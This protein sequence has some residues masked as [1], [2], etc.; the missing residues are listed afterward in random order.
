[1]PQGKTYQA[2]SF[3]SR[4]RSKHWKK[5]PG[6]LNPLKPK[7]SVRV[8]PETRALSK[9]Y[10]QEAGPNSMSGTVETQAGSGIPQHAFVEQIYWDRIT[11]G[12]AATVVDSHVFR[13]NSVFDPDET[14][15]GHQPKGRDFYA[16]IYN[17]YTVVSADYSV[18]FVTNDSTK[19]LVGCLITSDASIGATFDT[20]VEVM[21]TSSTKYNKKRLLYGTTDATERE[22]VSIRGHVDMKNFMLKTSGSFSD[23][24]S[25]AVGA[26]PSVP[27]RLIVYGCTEGG[28]AIASDALIC[29]VMV[30]YNVSYH[31]VIGATSS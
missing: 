18:T 3:T 5:N 8:T 15:T 29:R 20:Q 23:Q 4:M 24:F 16:G 26:N 30:K 17:D 9:L 6:I 1:M 22:I 28:A 12:D 2:K 13:L 25:A 7:S 11:I 31:G 10:H 19:K 21:E 14:G 27:I